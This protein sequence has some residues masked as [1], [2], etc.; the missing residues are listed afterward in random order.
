MATDDDDI[1]NII[2]GALDRGELIKERMVM[3]LLGMN[4]KLGDDIKDWDERRRYLRSLEMLI[5][6]CRW[7]YHRIAHPFSCECSDC[8]AA[9]N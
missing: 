7:T 6:A 2:R 1:G 3:R 4:F 8:T 5:D 9:G